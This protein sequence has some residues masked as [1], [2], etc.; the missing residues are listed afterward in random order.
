MDFTSISKLTK[1]KLMKILSRIVLATM[2]LGVVT[3]AQAD[4][5]RK[6]N[7]RDHYEYQ[8][9]NWYKNESISKAE[10]LKRHEEIFDRMDSNKDKVLTRDERKISGNL[11]RETTK[12]KAEMVKKEVIGNLTI[13]NIKD[14]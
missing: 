13:T 1:E 8:H 14:N 2:L 4:D 11:K 12:T 3:L 10:Y 7:G 5:D 9:H 6:K